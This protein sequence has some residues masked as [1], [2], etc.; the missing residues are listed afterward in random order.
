MLITHESDVADGRRAHHAHP[1]RPDLLDAE[2]AEREPVP[3]ERGGD[4]PDRLE[5]RGTHR[6]RSGLT[7]LGIMIGIAAVIL[8]VGLGEGAQQQVTSEIT[9][10]GH[11]P[12]YR[13]AGQLH[14]ELGHPGRVRVRLHTDQRRCRRPF[15][16][17]RGARHRGG[18]A[19]H[20]GV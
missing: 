14:V 2:L 13:L 5:A 9:A 8:T 7:V 11:Q 17:D 12:A 18:G 6:L 20:L 10:L 19:H 3:D 4:R 1:G 15:L 16:Q